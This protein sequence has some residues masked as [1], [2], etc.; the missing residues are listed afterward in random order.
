MNEE[1]KNEKII[2]GDFVEVPDNTK[3]DDKI[4]SKDTRV[5]VLLSSSLHG[6]I[7]ILNSLSNII[8]SNQ[9]KFFDDTWLRSA[10][11]VLAHPENR[12]PESY[13]DFQIKL[14]MKELYNSIINI[15]N[16]Q[17]KKSELESSDIVLTGPNAGYEKTMK[18]QAQFESIQSNTSKMIDCF[19]QIWY[20]LDA[21]VLTQGFNV[22]E[23]QHAANIDKIFD[24]ENTGSVF[25][26]LIEHIVELDEAI[27]ANLRER[28]GGG[29]TTEEIVKDNPIETVEDE[30]VEYTDEVIEYDE[31][32]PVE[33]VECGPEDDNCVEKEEETVE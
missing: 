5:T 26:I 1:L 21:M 32:E 15:L 28:M 14:Y 3:A 18:L 2:D 11:C 13:E 29:N 24:N 33:V 7:N 22:D 8:S 12:N 31:E 27:Y 20:I 6:Y 10:Y 23:A 4:I 25:D 19:A 16:A 9:E 30:N 17:A